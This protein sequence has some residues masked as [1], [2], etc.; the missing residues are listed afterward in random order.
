MA[1]RKRLLFW[2]IKAYL[3]KSGKAITIS[4]LI[5]LLLCGLFLF[6]SQ[7]IHG[8]IPISKKISIGIVG[9]YTQDTLPQSV[10]ERLSRGLTRIE[11]NGSVVPDVAESWK[12]SGDGKTYT[13]YIKPNVRFVNGQTVTSETINYN[14][15]DVTIAKPDKRTIV[16]TLKDAY[17]PFPVT[18][19]KPIFT[20]GLIGI[21]DYRIKEIKLNGNFIQSLT[22]VSTKNQ[23][24]V[25]V[26][27]FYPSENALKMAFMLGE[28]TEAKGLTTP[29]YK[30][31]S[32]A[33]YPNT[34]V[35]KK[36]NE[37][38]LVTLFFNTAD[39]TL[40]DKK[41]RLA[42]SYAMP[43]EYPGEQKAFLPYTKESMFYNTTLPERKQ[44][45]VHA[46][47]LLGSDEKASNSAERKITLTTLKKYRSAADEIKKSW[48]KIGVETKIEETESIPTKFQ[49]FLGDFSIPRDPDQYSLWHSEQPNN[50]SHYKNLRIDKL[51]EDGRK[52]TNWDERK[53]LYADFQKYLMDDAP[54]S[55]LYFPIEYTLIKK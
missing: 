14:F 42:L 17:A 21:N 9:A 43:N 22:L 40:S 52:T 53:K 35:I 2:L 12:V 45:Y 47:A 46:K 18:V 5:G 39:G 6:G 49:A 32:F 31:T 26:Y 27:Q 25:I 34:E 13:F 3:K 16:F 48:Q 7:Y 20:K 23:F 28:I 19:A 29:K 15:A 55:F 1:V 11:E 10:M 38:R 30:D 33:G 8:V 41:F 51:L 24:D 37:S 44:D 4:F 36:T 54:A 50:I